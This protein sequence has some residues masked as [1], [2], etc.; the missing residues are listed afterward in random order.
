MS[1]AIENTQHDFWRPP[2]IESQAASPAMVEVCDGCETEFMVGA[3][4]CH[5]CGAARQAQASG[6]TRRTATHAL[7]FFRFMELQNVKRW[8]GLPMASVVAFLAGLGC[9]LAAIA[10][11]LIYTVQNFA[12]FQAIQLWRIEWLLG[13][14]AAFLA[15]ILLKQAG[16]DQK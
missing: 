14:V 13:S 4:F 8:F 7:Q 11:G 6:V 15:G 16:A 9:V 2:V 1:E 12:D 5:V 10:V 3:Q